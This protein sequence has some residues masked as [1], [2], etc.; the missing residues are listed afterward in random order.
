MARFKALKDDPN[1]RMLVLSEEETVK[2]I[3]FLL[4][5][6]AETAPSGHMSGTI[7]EFRAEK[8]DGMAF[9]LGV[10]VETSE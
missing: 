8:D 1:Y 4:A 7:P 5:H 10:M 3:S 6:L 9:R 2:L